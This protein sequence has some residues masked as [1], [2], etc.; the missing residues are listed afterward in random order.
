MK[1]KIQTEL[2]KATEVTPD[3]GETLK[4]QSYLLALMKGIAKLSEKD[5]DALSE[6][7]QDWF[8]EAAD[9]KAAKK[10]DVPGFPDLEEPKEE[11]AP[12]RRG[13]R[14]AD[15]EPEA[16]AAGL[17][18]PKKG[19]KVIVTTKKGSKVKGKVVDPNDGGELVIDDGS[20]DGDVGIKLANVE[21]LEFVETKAAEPE[22]TGRRRKAAD[23]EDPPASNEPEV[24][25]TVQLE[26]AR[27]SIKL[28]NLIELTD[29]T[30]V[31][32]DAAGEEMEYDRDRIKSLVVK[33]KNA[34]VKA[35]KGEP[36]TPARRGASKGEDKADGGE[37]DSKAGAGK[38]TLHA[39]EI[40]LDD[41]SLSKDQVLKALKKEFPDVK[42]NT[43]NLIYTEVHKL[44][45][46]MKERKMLK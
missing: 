21:K 31:I 44:V 34:T 13:R 16:P 17:R 5:W 24:G 8:N 27:G 11:E 1:S 2:A 30:I 19:D 26:T 22:A 29:A 18:E 12:E 41:L 33:V 35:G 25:D 9:A 36:E 42:E 45:G 43:I 4:S 14:G 3:K 40:I 10:P 6:P 28:G 39:R 38:A 46:M 32:K 15:A 23:D 20:K 37:K 7:A